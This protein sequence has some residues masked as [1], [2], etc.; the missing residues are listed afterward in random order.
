MSNSAS[1]CV[2][3][4]ATPS[5][6]CPPFHHPS[7]KAAS[8]W[9]HLLS[10]ID[11]EPGRCQAV[12][13]RNMAVQLRFIHAARRARELKMPQQTQQRWWRRNS[14]RLVVALALVAAVVLPSCGPSEISPREIRRTSVSSTAM[15]SVGYDEARQVLTIEFPNGSVYEYQGVRAGNRSRAWEQ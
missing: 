13:W 11:T 10:A 9:P 7:N 12:D 2:S 8:W 4:E 1:V 14:P 6:S 5:H 15:R 3:C